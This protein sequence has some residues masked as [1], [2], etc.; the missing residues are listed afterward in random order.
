MNHKIL[1]QSIHDIE[2]LGVIC[3]ILFNS[4][5]LLYTLAK[6]IKLISAT[7]ILIFLAHY[8]HNQTSVLVLQTPALACCQ[9]DDILAE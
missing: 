3:T 2:D 1:I 5:W 7:S 4:T 9:F 6:V 8:Q